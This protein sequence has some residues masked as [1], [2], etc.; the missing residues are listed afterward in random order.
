MLRNC[1]RAF[2]A[3]SLL[4]WPCAAQAAPPVYTA[5]VD[6]GSGGTRLFLYKVTPGPY[7][8]SELILQSAA[9]DVPGTPYEEDDGIDNYA[10]FP[11]GDP[12]VQ[13]FYAAQNVNPFVMVPLWEAMKGKLAVLSPPVAE[14][15]VVVK[16][17]ATAGM[18]T[19]VENCGQA[20]A[21]NL[22]SVIKSGMTAAGL[23]N[24]ANEARII[25]GATEEGLWSFINANDEYANAFGRP[26]H[27][28]PPEAPVGVLEVGGS[29]V[30][31]V[32]PYTPTSPGPN[33]VQIQINNR[34][35]KVHAQS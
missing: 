17:F 20:A 6:A 13:A 22:F 33:D 31:I 19:A 11:G 34:V 7:P 16:V 9:A 23:T 29:S 28:K 14:S 5:I 4:L 18:R 24:P 27:P 2:A 35:F 32:Y 21:D 15:D 10:C 8:V 26:N 1:L 12:S 30:Q 25:D 3:L